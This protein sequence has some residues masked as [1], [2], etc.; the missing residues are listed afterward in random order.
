M[1]GF[2]KAFVERTKKNFAAARHPW[3]KGVEKAVR[4]LA[5]N[6]FTDVT[7]ILDRARAKPR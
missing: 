7:Q 1:R 6:R 5:P 4:Q 2:E 3:D